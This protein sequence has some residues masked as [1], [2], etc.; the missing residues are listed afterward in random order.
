MTDGPAAGQR[1]DPGDPRRRLITAIETTLGRHGLSP[2]VAR[3]VR[4]LGRTMREAMRVQPLESAALV[5]AA[6][7]V[8]LGAT[9]RGRP[10]RVDAT[11]LFRQAV[12]GA[13][14]VALHTHPDSMPL[15]VRDVAILLEQRA[16]GTL[17]LVA[18]IGRDGSWSIMSVAPGTT[19]ADLATLRAAVAERAAALAGQFR[20]PPY[21]SAAAALR[22]HRHEVWRHTALDLGLRYD[23]VEGRT[24]S[25]RPRAP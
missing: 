11:A 21:P 19:P 18:A 17:G 6:T 25:S 15:S 22:A 13:T 1:T 20:A 4:A 12:P 9:I 23:R 16:L 14:Y 5:D 3:R 7:G 8:Q 24:R 2:A 10:D